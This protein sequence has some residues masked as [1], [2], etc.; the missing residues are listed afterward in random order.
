MFS[1]KHRHESYAK[2]LKREKAK[3]QGRPAAGRRRKKRYSDEEDEVED[4]Q[5]E[6]LRE[7]QVDDRAKKKAK[8]YCCDMCL[9]TDRKH[10]C[11]FKKDGG[12]QHHQQQQ[13]Q[14]VDEPMRP[15]TP[16]SEEEPEVDYATQIREQLA[17]LPYV[18][19]AGESYEF[20]ESL[21]PPPNA[22]SLQLSP[23]D[24]AKWDVVR[25]MYL[26]DTVQYEEEELLSALTREELAQPTADLEFGSTP[27][28]LRQPRGQRRG[29]GGDS[30]EELDEF[31]NIPPESESSDEEDHAESDADFRPRHTR[32]SSLHPLD[33]EDDDFATGKR[34]SRKVGRPRKE[35]KA[36]AARARQQG[37][38]S[39]S[40]NQAYTSSAANAARQ[41]AA[42]N[43][44]AYMWPGVQQASFNQFFQQQFLIQQQGKEPNNVRTWW[45]FV[46]K[47]VY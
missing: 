46:E 47:S 35:D 20:I 13:Q 26:D 33:E 12:Q 41:L 44:G 5:D 3:L 7:Y 25:R 16:P 6:L 31:A 27:R 42:L 40:S 34:R 29:A 9:S 28:T 18:F 32:D 10:V 39:S 15:L 36:A 22:A 45:H 14:E 21:L 43:A 24:A 11:P 4:S 19:P 2:Q 30:L 8:I 23:E 1:D 37:S 38:S 17:A